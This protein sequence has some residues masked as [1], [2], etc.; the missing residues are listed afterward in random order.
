VIPGDPALENFELIW[1]FSD[2]V[3]YSQLSSDE[4]NRFS[5]VLPGESL[6]LWEKYVYPSSQLYESHLCQLYAQKQIQWPEGASFHFTGER[7]DR[8]VLAMLRQQIAATESSAVLFFW[9]AEVCARTDWGLFLTHWDDF[10]Y[11]SDDSNVIVLPG[12]D[13]AVVYIEDVWHILPRQDDRT[14]F[15]KIN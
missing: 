6:K 4:F 7:E 3:K 1:R 14:I 13:K 5:P 9:S 2:A 11:P 8:K 10:C 15:G 12:I